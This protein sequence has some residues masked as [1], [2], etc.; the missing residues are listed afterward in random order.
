[1]FMHPFHTSVVWTKGGLTNLSYRKWSASFIVC[2]AWWTKATGIFLIYNKSFT[3]PLNAPTIAQMNNLANKYI[4]LV[5][6]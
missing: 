2:S 3:R 1:M 5:G 6:G 4:D